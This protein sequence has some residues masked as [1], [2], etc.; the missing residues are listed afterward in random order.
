MKNGKCP[1]SALCFGY[2]DGDCDGCVIGQKLDKMQKRIDRLKKQNKTLTIQRAKA[3][4]PTAD[5]V[6]V[7]RC[8][9]CIYYKSNCCFNRQWDFESSV[10]VPLV[11]ENDF[12]SYGER[13]E[14]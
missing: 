2:R 13:R 4:T 7:V 1:I 12:C 3:L 6:E 14:E 9:D 10:E 5:V 8:K 11:R